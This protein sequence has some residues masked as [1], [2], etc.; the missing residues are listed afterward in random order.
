MGFASFR[1]ETAIQ[2]QD[3]VSSILEGSLPP[4]LLTTSKVGK[5]VGMKSSRQE[6]STVASSGLPV[7][8]FA[9]ISLT[10]VQRHEFDYRRLPKNHLTQLL[11]EACK[12][13]WFFIFLHLSGNP[14]VPSNRCSCQE[15]SQFPSLEAI[16]NEFGMK[17]PHARSPAKPSKGFEEDN[18][19][20]SRLQE[21]RIWQKMR[22]SKRNS[23]TF[24]KCKSLMN[25][26]C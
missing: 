8:S 16:A 3:G 15:P 17:D 10:Q 11:K 5:R 25:I 19:S 26:P 1:L 7:F 12:T 4:T 20:K 14:A 13:A 18:E 6:C 21:G 2:H 24:R 23:L 9:R 22:I